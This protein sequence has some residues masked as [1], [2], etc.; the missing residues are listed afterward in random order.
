MGS[1]RWRDR[2]DPAPVE[3]TAACTPNED[4]ELSD[5]RLSSP[6]PRVH[7]RCNLRRRHTPDRLRA[8][9]RSKSARRE[10]EDPAS[11]LRRVRSRSHEPWARP[12]RSI[13]SSHWSSVDRTMLPTSSPRPA[14]TRDRDTSPR[15]PSNVASRRSSARAKGSSDQPNGQSL[16]IGC[17]ST[18]RY[19]E[20]V[21]P[22]ESP[23]VSHAPDVTAPSPNH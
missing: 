8:R 9:I 20:E 7:T 4:Q 22:E 5:A 11:D 21:R 6:R 13:T 1:G 10:H 2:S 3:N 16:A 14:V 15:T 12:Y 19:S 18:D 23:G 17:R